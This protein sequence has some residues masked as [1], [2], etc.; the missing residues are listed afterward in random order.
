[1][2]ITSSEALAPT[3]RPVVKPYGGARQTTAAA[4]EG[5]LTV[6]IGTEFGRFADDSRKHPR[7]RFPVMNLPN[8]VALV[9]GATGGIGPGIARALPGPLL[10]PVFALLI[11]QMIVP[12]ADAGMRGRKPQFPRY[13]MPWKRSSQ[14]PRPRSI[15][16]PDN[17]PGPPGCRVG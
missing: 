1:V 6:E 16:A 12:Y 14:W 8:K 13:A 15:S 17:E 2:N 4:A 11:P 9:T 5:R 7:V 3:A 10:L